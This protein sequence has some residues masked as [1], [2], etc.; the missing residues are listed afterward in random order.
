[1]RATQWPYP[2]LDMCARDASQL[3]ALLLVD[4]S[5]GR[6]AMLFLSICSFT[7]KS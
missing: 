6:A 7:G 5:V 2:S 1:V 3:D 4:V